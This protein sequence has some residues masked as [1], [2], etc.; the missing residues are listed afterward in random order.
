MN[1]EIILR[2]YKDDSEAVILRN[3]NDFNMNNKQQ[4]YFY[5][6]RLWIDKFEKHDISHVV[7]DIN[8]FFHEFEPS[9]IFKEN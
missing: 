3:V 1:A 8:E 6:E 7:V 9:F 4:L 2:A 5:D